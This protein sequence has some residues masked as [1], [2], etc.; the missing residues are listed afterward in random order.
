MSDFILPIGIDAENVINPLNETIS[1]MERVENTAKETGKSLNDAF[2]QGGRAAE[3]IEEKLKPITKDLEAIKVLGKQAGKELAEAFNSRNVDPS[4]LDKAVAGFKEKLN[5]LSGKINIEI[6]DAKLKVFEKQL[7]NTKDGLGELQVALNFTKE[8]MSG[9][10]PNSEEFQA[11][12]ENVTFVE[13][14]LQSYAEEV[15]ST[16]TKQKSLKAQLREMKAELAEMEMAGLAG[17]K[18]YNDLR[19]AAGELEDQIGDTNAQIKAMASDTRGFDALISGAQGLTGAFAA[20]QGMVGLLGDENKDLEK[21]LLKVNSAMAILQGLQAVAETLNKDS[22]FSIMFLS[23]ARQADTVATQA[24]TGATTLQTVAMNGAN[25]AAKALRIGL[26]TIGFGL[27]IAAVAYLVANWDKLKSSMEKLLPATKNMGTAWDTLKTIFVGVGGALIE[28]VIAPFKI[29]MK[30]I[31]EGLDAAVEQAKQSYDVVNNYNKAA[32]EQAKRNAAA[33]ALDMKKARMEQWKQQLD[34]QEAEGKDVYKSREKWMKN[35]IAIKKK[36]GEDTKE[37]ENDLALFQARKRG[38]DAK[39]A[40]DH[41]KKLAEDAKKAAEEAARKRKE[42]AEKAAEEAK[43]Q[44]ELVEK[45]T[46]EINKLR[47][48]KVQESYERE[49]KLIREEAA[50]R[51]K[52]LKKDNATTAEAIAKQKELEAAIN[53]DTIRRIAEL[54]KKRTDEQVKLRLEGA[55][56]LANLGKDSAEKELELNRIENEK[57]LADIEEKYKNETELKAKLIE[58]QNAYFEN[59]NKEIQIESQKKDLDLAEEKAVLMIELMQQYAGDSVEVE[60]QKQLALLTIRRDYAKQNL[61]QLINSGKA[62]NDIEVL[63]AKKAVNDAE[64]ALE[65][66]SKGGKKFSMMKLL[67]LD[68]Y[69]PEEQKAITDAAQQLYSNIQNIADGIVEAYQQQIDKKQEV[70]DQYNAEIDDLESQLDKEKELRDNGLANNVENLQKEIE[71]KKAARDEE[72][73]Q[74]KEMQ[75]KQ[76]QIKKAQMAADTVIQLV[77]MITA[78]TEIF[79]SLAGIPFIGI[80]LAIATIATMFGAF[81]VA[82]VNAFNA[83]KSG[84]QF[85]EG[86]E[87]D[88]ASHTAG[89]VKYYAA[90]GKS[91]VKELEGGEYVIKKK[92]YGKYKK[93]V[94]AINSDDFSGLNFNDFA[95]QGLFEHLGISLQNDNVFEAVQDTQELKSLNVNFNGGG[96]SKVF[97]S[98]DEKL[99]VIATATKEKVEVWED[100]EFYYKKKGSKITKTKKR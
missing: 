46:D 6:D 78:S 82:K 11:L 37:A 65:N 1:T 91:G 33:H 58:A 20:T 4:R 67:G 57:A 86:G 16:T 89:G 39:A 32:N 70:I 80:P 30:L 28:Y 41:A 40:Q 3:N 35:N 71:A 77:N 96:D 5:G 88:G 97:E 74:Q 19:K 100:A 44:A 48:D 81:A 60:E 72:I 27:I 95:V 73:R 92:S 7:A 18:G 59:R 51:I 84:Q 23:K 69:S 24:Q 8:V 90:D 47:I 75:E 83:I 99:G 64:K 43:R 15:E 10:D 55:E 34:I 12:A 29:A 76:A 49:T 54:E 53:E 62:E 14:A 85:G 79:K 13:T 38:E 63:R 87:I 50:K 94:Q 66:A 93:L 45:Y 98:M 52:D 21:A 22:A 25:I 68:K 36:E 61:Q 31:T 26:A 9:L 2:A 56:L 42:A 17:T